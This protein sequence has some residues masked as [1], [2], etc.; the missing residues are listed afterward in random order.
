MAA[1]AAQPIR[2]VAA[3]DSHGC[4]KKAAADGAV[5]LL[6][7]LVH[8]ARARLA[9]WCVWEQRRCRA[10]E[11]GRVRPIDRQIVLRNDAPPHSLYNIHM[12]MQNIHYT[13]YDTARSRRLCSDSAH[14]AIRGHTAV[15]RTGC[16]QA[17]SVSLESI[18][19]GTLESDSTFDTHSPLQTI[20]AD[21]T[22]AR[23]RVIVGWS[24]RTRLA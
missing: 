22:T 19:D 23:G 6:T 24:G 7:F 2:N 9:L 8:A 15:C 4:I 20:W 5:C 21:V 17:S 18:A 12:H 10:A 3:T 16:A 14:E 1:A 13:T 11:S